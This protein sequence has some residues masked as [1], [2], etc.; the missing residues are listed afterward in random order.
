MMT[1][2]P[3][4]EEQLVECLRAR[5]SDA[6][7]ELY[8]RHKDALFDYCFHLLKDR[9]RAEDAVHEAFMMA[10]KDIP[11]LKGTHSFRSWMFSIVRHH[12]LNQIRGRKLFDELSDE[13][14][15]NDPDPLEVLITNE[16]STNFAELL[17]RMR[18]QFKELIV[19]KDFED[20]TYAEI[21]RI[22]GLSLASVRVHLY[23]ARKAL[24]KVYTKHYGEKI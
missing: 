20:L 13:V 22:T 17:D 10:W 8:T 7:A 3:E 9:A 23:R 16:R 18:P 5:S 4:P 1:Q 21:A 6:F 19:L 2:T 15:M 11:S 14:P 24:A 12:A